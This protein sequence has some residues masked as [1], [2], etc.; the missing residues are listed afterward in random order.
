LVNKETRAMNSP[1][2]TDT[3]HYLKEILYF[4]KK[5]P[6]GDRNPILSD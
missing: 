4:R 3:L 6:N 1:G 5:D 2:H